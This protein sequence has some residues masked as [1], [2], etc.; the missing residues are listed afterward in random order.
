MQINVQPGSHQPV[1][2]LDK[3]G[4]ALVHVNKYDYS[5]TIYELQSWVKVYDEDGVPEN[6]ARVVVQYPNGEDRVLR[7]DSNNSSTEGY[8]YFKDYFEVSD[9]E[10]AI[11]SGKKFKFR[12]DDHD[13]NTDQIE[14]QLTVNTLA[15]PVNLTPSSGETVSSRPIISCDPVDGAVKYRVRI[16]TDWGKLIHRSDYLDV[17]Y[18]RPP[19]NLLESD[20]LYT[21]RIYAY[22]EDLFKQEID[23]VSVNQYTYGMMPYFIV[24]ST[25]DGLNININ[26]IDKTNCPT[27]KSMVTVSDSKGM[28]VP[29]LTKNDF[30]VYLDG[31]IVSDFSVTNVDSGTSVASVAMALDYS[32][33]MS[34]QDITAMESAAESFVNQTGSGDLCE[35]IK[36][37]TNIEVA[38]AFTA[39]KSDLINAIFRDSSVGSMTSLYDAI[40]LGL[41]DTDKQSGRKAVIALTDGMNNEGTT[42]Y[43]VVISKAK[44]LQIPV[45]TIGLGSNVNEQI[46]EEISTSTGGVYYRSPS[47]DD[48]ESIYRRIVQ[49]I[50]NQ[51]IIEYTDTNDGQP[52]K[53]AIEVNNGGESGKDE[54]SYTACQSG[55]EVVSERTYD[56]F[57]YKPGETYK[58]TLTIK[59]NGNLTAIGLDETIPD[60]WTFVSVGGDNQPTWI[61][62]PGQTGK[63]EFTW[64]NPPPSPIVFDYT[65]AV[66]TD[67]DGDKEI[68]GQIRYRIGN[69]QEQTVDTTVTVHEKCIS[70]Y[71]S[72]DYRPSDWSINLLEL[73][74]VAYYYKKSEYHC[75]S[76]SDDG[77]AAGL[78][79]RNCEP[80]NSDYNPQ[81][82]SIGQ[83]ELLRLIQ[84]YNT[85]EYHLDS[86]SEDG[87]QAGPPQIQDQKNLDTNDGGWSFGHNPNHRRHGRINNKQP[88]RT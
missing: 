39:N 6:I 25:L 36:F 11:Y 18:Y 55:T 21:Y 26:Q 42:D 32:G 45:F 27:I 17:P 37:A 34:T 23:N 60:D 20:K 2:G 77:Y 64:Q 56:S 58:L 49:A 54:S 81:D 63:L 78:G 44:Q 51:Y 40:L 4:I 53:L 1:I 43:Q 47:S 61:P 31:T 80:H 86:G 69:G 38:Q 35:I 74:R 48:L 76:S 9:F 88:L 22:R 71:H 66:P 8:Y 29:G 85:G 7:F 67:D 79:D 70:N 16:Y 12:V 5:G 10:P 15:V 30:T 75:D 84:F 57:C 62:D 3:Y 82:W 33:S 41:E 52:R 14:E 83:S 46:L 65:V 28:A 13:G 87:F 68:S 72:A 50:N 24:D 19:A 59:H 73:M